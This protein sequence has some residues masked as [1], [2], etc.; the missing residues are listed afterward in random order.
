MLK[1]KVS[2]LYVLNLKEATAEEKKQ[3]AAQTLRDTLVEAAAAN[4]TIDIPEAMITS[5]TDRM[6]QEF[7]QRLQA[8]RYELRSLLSILWSR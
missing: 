8:T 5:E 4:A 2:T 7:G 3:L 6:L 1:L